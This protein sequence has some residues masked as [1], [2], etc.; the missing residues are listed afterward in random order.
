MEFV[1]TRKCDC[2]Q[3]EIYRT[4]KEGK[5][6]PEFWHGMREIQETGSAV[7]KVRFQFPGRATME[8]VCD[9]ATRTCIENYRDGPF[10]GTKK[11]EVVEES[12]QITLRASW[13]IKLSF[14]LRLMKKRLEEHFTE[15]SR[16]ALE[17]ICSSASHNGNSNNRS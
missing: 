10:T 12:G 1:V 11:T 16:N 4:I 3:D 5:R 7:Y 2:D 17:R 13:N 15:G 14:S 9:D 8:Y 6:L